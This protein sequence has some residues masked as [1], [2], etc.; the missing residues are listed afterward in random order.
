MGITLPQNWHSSRRRFTESSVP[1]WEQ[2]I[3]QPQDVL[4]D[5]LVRLV[6]QERLAALGIDMGVGA[7]ERRKRADLVPS[8]EHLGFWVTEETSNVG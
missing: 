1:H 7:E 3:P 4:D 6:E 8:N 2:G 5:A